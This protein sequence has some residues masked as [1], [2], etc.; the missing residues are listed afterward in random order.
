MKKT[1]N[2]EKVISEYLYSDRTDFAPI[3]L[4][5]DKTTIIS[6]LDKYAFDHPV[7]AKDISYIIKN[8]DKLRFGK[9]TYSNLLKVL[10]KHIED[11]NSK[12]IEV[13]YNLLIMCKDETI[14]YLERNRIS[15][16]NLKSIVKLFSDTYKYQEYE[17]NYLNGI[18]SKYEK[19]N[20]DK[21]KKSNKYINIK[22]S[23]P[24]EKDKALLMRIKCLYISKLSIEE[25]CSLTGE[26]MATLKD[27]CIFRTKNDKL[28]SKMK[29]I[30]ARTPSDNFNKT[31]LN[32]AYEA[33][34]N[35]DFDALDYYNITRLKT[36]DY[37]DIIQN[38][39]SKEDFIRI[40]KK[41]NKTVRMSSNIN[42]VNELKSKKIIGGREI[43][44]DEKEAIFNYLDENRLPIGLYTCA[45]KKYLSGKLD[46][47][48]TKRL[49]KE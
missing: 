49:V 11:N 13:V 15:V 20:D 31:M 45:L 10:Q 47:N 3:Y 22:L 5:G 46:I 9:Y 12:Y 8:F 38:Q 17:I 4:L 44:Y 35:P 39:L 27:A 34:T 33:D 26:D 36:S 18:V 28:K 21:S 42:K 48:N 30:L 16:S 19:I 7:Y 24:S 41:I 37:R 1:I 29:D 6:H 25:F 40:I 32:I 2:Y 14:D 43:A 23:N